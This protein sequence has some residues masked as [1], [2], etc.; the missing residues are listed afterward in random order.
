MKDRNVLHPEYFMMEKVAGTENIVNLTPAPGEVY[1][2]GTL[3]NK[4]TLWKDDTAALFGLGPETVPDDGFA[5]LGKYAQHWWKRT[6]YAGETELASLGFDASFFSV[7]DQNNRNVQVSNAVG[8]D[9]ETGKAVLSG[10]IQSVELFWDNKLTYIKDKLMGLVGKYLIPWLN[11]AESDLV[12]YIDPSATES[13]FYTVNTASGSDH[14]QIHVKNN[15]IYQVNA[16]LVPT[17]SYVQSSDRSAYPD[18]GKQDGYEYEYIGIPFDNAV[19]APKIEIGSYI[20]TGTYGV[21]NPNSLALNFIPKVMLFFDEDKLLKMSTNS[22]NGGESSTYPAIRD[23]SRVTT[24]YTPG[25]V[26][27]SKSVVGGASPSGTQQ[28]ANLSG[29]TKFDAGVLSWYVERTSGFDEY[30]YYG[31]GHQFNAKGTK[32]LYVI[33]G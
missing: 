25:G 31:Y 14:L 18:S 12:Y 22:Y 16:S 17:V 5:F 27:F 1:E 8:V 4:A 28:S 20:G 33:L 19:G 2:E 29:F 26:P 13:D 15:K 23:L 30:T 7:G 3:I 21:D 6:S 24:E 10:D 11:N 9:L 32:Y